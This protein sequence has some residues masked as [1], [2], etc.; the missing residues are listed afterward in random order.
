MP[1]PPRAAPILLLAPELVARGGTL[2]VIDLAREL[3]R[4]EV[5]AVVV[6]PGGAMTGRLAAA[7]VDHRTVEFGTG[8]FVDLVGLWRLR[9]VGQAIAPRLVHVT[10]ETL[11][12]IG[13][14]LARGLGVPAI[15][16]AHGLHGP[17]GRRVLG[18]AWFRRPVKAVVAISQAVREELVNAS[19]VPSTLV[20]SIHGGVDV[21][22]YPAVPAPPLPPGRIPT[23]GVLSRLVA[24]R[25]LQDLIAAARLLVDAGIEARFLI[26]GEGPLDD[27]LRRRVRETGMAHAVT[28]VPPP[29]S[30]ERV[31]ESIDVFVLPSIREGLGA[32]LLEAMACARPVVATGVGGVFA[33]VEDGVN[34]YLVPRGD[35][36]ALADRIRR[37][38]ADPEQARRMGA[39]GRKIVEERFTVQRMANEMIALYGQ[40]ARR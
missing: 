31:I 18:S 17:G 32:G 27:V 13:P 3:L 15:V 38:L 25:G 36:A 22:R 39:E 5:P 23:V 4:R 20:R 12:R 10:S 11:D 16:T 24:S 40:V 9:A 2:Y 14:A 30:I 1:E 28:I 6:S 37:L 19:R 26:A 7:G 29:E 21:G 35:T 8:R 34:G 33:V